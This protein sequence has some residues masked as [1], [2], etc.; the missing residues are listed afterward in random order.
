MDS[1]S[2]HP[3]L[4]ALL[5]LWIALCFP[6]RAQKIILHGRQHSLFRYRM[7]Q[8]IEAYP[9]MKELVLTLVEPR[10][11]ESVTYRQSVSEFSLKAIPEADERTRFTDRRGNR[12]LQLRWQRPEQPVRVEAGFVARTEVTLTDLPLAQT[13]FPLPELPPETAAYL[14]PTELVQ[15]HAQEIV[16]LS[17]RLTEDAHNA[18]EAVEAILLWIVGHVRYVLNPPAFDALSTLKQG[19]GNCQNFSHLAAA[20]LRASGF[21]TRIVNGITADL[22]YQVA[23]DSSSFQFQMARGRHSWIEIYLPGSG[24]IPMDAQ[25]SEFFVSSRYLRLEVG[26]DNG[27][28]INDGLVR[29]RQSRQASRERPAV[30]E[31]LEVDPR[32]DQ[33]HL[34]AVLQALP[35][36]KILLAAPVGGP[37][38][39][40]RGP[41]P[42]PP[43]AEPAAEDAFDPASLHFSRPMVL[44]NLQFPEGLDFSSV[45]REPAAGVRNELRKNF[46]VETAEYVTGPNEFAQAFEVDRP[47]LLDS[48]GLALAVFGGEGQLWL[49]LREDHH[50][51]P[52]PPAATSRPVRVK[53]ARAPGYHWVNFS[54]RHQGL[55]LGPGRYWLVLRYRGSP[56]VNWFFNYGKSV[57]PA[58]GTRSRPAGSKTWRNILAFEFVYRV[59]GKYPADR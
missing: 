2:A 7:V 16:R 21:P 15:S 44:G 30:E 12:I 49:E 13:P 11:F 35:F 8:H 48:I 14:E 37:L 1:R 50:G 5:G 56:I 43:T 4:P 52:G 23:T 55:V 3:F 42:S 18:G 45:A 59:Q 34:S 31:V 17:R 57:G 33:V 36:P 28:T 38:L 46:L 47:L 27:E 54:F 22:P 53:P 51:Q 39:A 20:L 29:W 19:S 10:S 58:D 6:L 9:G 24:W 32:E 25:Q 40:A 41:Q 26:V